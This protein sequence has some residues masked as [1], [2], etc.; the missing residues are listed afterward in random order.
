MSNINH[1][2]VENNLYFMS[3]P[4]FNVKSL[5]E[6][7]LDTIYQH[8]IFYLGYK[9]LKCNHILYAFVVD[10]IQFAAQ[11]CADKILC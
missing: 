5:F 1:Q 3:E 8:N 4:L 2:W 11:C 7:E 9:S 6:L 10:A